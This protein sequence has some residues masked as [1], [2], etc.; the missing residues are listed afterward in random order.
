MRFRPCI[1]LHD[2]VVKQIVGGTLT[3]GGG[4]SLPS[5]SFTPAPVT[6]FVATQGAAHF[7][8]LYAADGLRGGHVIMLGAGNEEPALAALR[9]YPGGLQVGGG[10]TAA[11]AQ[12]YLDAGASHVIV[13]SYVFR[14]ARGAACGHVEWGVWLVGAAANRGFGRAAAGPA[15]G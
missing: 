4:A 10:V 15:A 5:S 6:N 14:C 1:D 8:A 11:N 3:D 12:R 13:T 7:A 9:A 2:G